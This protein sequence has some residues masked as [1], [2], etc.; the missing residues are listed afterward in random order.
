MIETIQIF[1]GMPVC[2]CCQ[3]AASEFTSQFPGVRVGVNGAG[4]LRWI[5]KVKYE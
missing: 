2:H 3:T 4:G 5:C 1:A